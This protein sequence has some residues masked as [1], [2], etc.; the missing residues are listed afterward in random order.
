MENRKSSPTK[1][2]TLQYVYE[3]VTDV[4]YPA[5]KEDFIIAAEDMHAPVEVLD[6]FESLPDEEY[7]SSAEFGQAI[8]ELLENDT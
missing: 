2:I 4:E 3:Y 5:W 7:E 6:L 1:H 8:R